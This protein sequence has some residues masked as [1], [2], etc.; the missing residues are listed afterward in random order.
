[1]LKASE[2]NL[3]TVGILSD[4]HGWVDDAILDRFKTVDEIWHAG[5]IGNREVA[6]KLAAIKPLKG[7]YGN[8]DGAFLRSFFPE[9]AFFVKAGLKVLMTHIGGSPGKYPANVRAAI[10]KYDPDVFICGHSHILKVV[11]TGKILHI[12]PGAAGR[13]GFH[14]QRTLLLMGIRDRK[15]AHVD[16]VELGPR[17]GNP[18]SADAIG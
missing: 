1:M 13:Q 5:D 12:N 8:I 11:R 17:G 6:D 4:T 15:V 16:V 2:S 9:F 10:Q 14:Q 18:G 3:V 7:V